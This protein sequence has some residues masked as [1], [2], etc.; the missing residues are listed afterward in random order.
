MNIKT[1]KQIRVYKNKIN[2][3]RKSEGVKVYR[4]ETKK[5]FSGFST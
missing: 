4:A 3:L 1:L 5:M 2:H